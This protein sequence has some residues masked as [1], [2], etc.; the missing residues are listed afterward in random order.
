MFTTGF[1]FFFGLF[2]AF[3]AAALVYGYTTGGNHVGPLSLGWKGGVGDHIGYGVLVGLAAVSLTISLVLVSFRDADASAQARLQNLAEVLTDQPVTAS[4][5]PVVAS[6]GAGA[7]AVGLVLHPMVFVLGLAVIVLSMVEWTMDAWADRATGDTAVNRE[8]R[9]RIMA[10]IEIPVV[11]AL[12]VGVIVLAA[13]RILLT[14]SQL[15]AVTVAGVVSALILGGAW[16]YA[17]RPGLGRRLV[18]VLGTVGALLL[19]VGGVLAAVAG[20]RDFAHHTDET[21]E[22]TGEESGEPP[23]AGEH[24]G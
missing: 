7:A 2:A 15:G 24:G 12:A 10:P 1:K 19:L 17:S 3:C 20:E 22:E 9:N 6:F 11:G 14:V 13:S 23:G 16:V 21:H 5:W 8:L 18:R 4:F